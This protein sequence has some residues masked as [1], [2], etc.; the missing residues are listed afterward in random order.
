MHSYTFNSRRS[1]GLWLLPWL[2]AFCLLCV[3]LYGYQAYWLAKG[4][5]PQVQDTRQNWAFH[6]LKARL[7]GNALVFAGASRTL[8]GIDLLT[9]RQ[10][11]P[12][13]SP[14]MLAVNG[15]Y[16]YALL[17]HLASDPLFDGIL[18]LDIDARGLARNNH[19]ALA[20][21]LNYY[22]QDFSPARAVHQYLVRH[23]QNN[24]VFA[25]H[26]F[27]G[28][29]SLAYSLGMPLPS[30]SNTSMDLAR[31]AK[32]DLSQTNNGALA[33]W[34][35]EG[36]SQDL[37]TNPPPSS[38]QWLAELQQVPSWVAQIQ[39]RG[40]D[41]IFYVPPVQGRQA[42]LAERYFPRDAYWQAFIDRYGLKG[43][44]AADIAALQQFKLPDESHLDFRD[45]PAYTELL[46]QAFVQR[47]WL[48]P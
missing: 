27:S 45:K 22:N 21:Y 6:R 33:D 35:A 1:L 32:L 40:G 4:Y 16:A 42:E 29:N 26:P 24:F 7:T 48:T 43:L 15:H 2:A 25:S 44:D 37:Q 23:W 18:V 39:R 30:L 34:F 38:D 20:P 31:N 14:I 10:Q 19:A 13:Y 9:V 5:Q 46:L 28:L 36:V 12:D 8:Y 41:V 17:E 11:L 47:G 3:S